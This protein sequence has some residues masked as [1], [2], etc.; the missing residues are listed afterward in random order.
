[1]A[2]WVAR[3][4]LEAG[5]GVDA[6]VR[7]NR[8]YL[9]G[10]SVQRITEMAAQHA[11][12]HLRAFIPVAAMTAISKHRDA[13]EPV[14]L[15]SGSLDLLVAPLAQLVNAD[16]YC[17]STLSAE[18]GILTGRLDGTH[19]VGPGKVEVAKRLADRGGF[20]LDSSTAYGDRISDVPLMARVQDAVAVNPK[21]PLARYAHR[22]GWEVVDWHR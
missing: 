12:E 13:G 8:A 2:R 22:R 3:A 6:A 19:P 4:A 1:A 17:A 20:S 14:F 18:D 15:L 16:G 9:A 7:G 10:K 21:R 11:A 5:S